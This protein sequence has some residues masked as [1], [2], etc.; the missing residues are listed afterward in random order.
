MLLAD[1][2]G[3]NIPKLLMPKATAVWLISNTSLS[4]K[5]IADFCGFHVLEIQG[6]ADG[7]VARGIIGMDPVTQGQLSMQEIKRCELDPEGSLRLSDTA[8]KL[9]RAQKQAK[10]SKYTPIARRQDKP[11]AIAWLLKNC[12]ELSD[13]Q[14]AKLIS[15]TKTTVQSIKDKTHWNTNNIKPKDPVLLGLCSQTELNLLYESVKAKLNS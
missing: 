1:F 13:F 15:S 5:Q 10:S 2:M 6:M 4:F 11:E 14:I 3:D 7:D 9:L 12:P 8:L